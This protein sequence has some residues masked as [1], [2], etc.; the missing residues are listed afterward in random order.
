MDSVTQA[1]LNE[2]RESQALTHADTDSLFE[3][4]CNY[5]ILSDIY[6]D[7]FDVESVNTGEGEFGID[8][9][10]VLVNDHLIEDVDQLTDVVEDSRSVSV[11]FVFTQAKTTSK[12]NSGEVSKFLIAVR[13]FFNDTL[14]L[15]QSTKIQE[16]H[17]IKQELLK[18]AAKFTSGLPKLDMYYASLGTWA[19]DENINAIARS[20]KEEL[21]G[22][23]IFSEVAVNFVDARQLQALYYQTKNAFKATLP[24][25]NNVS[26]PEMEGIREAYLGTVPASTYLSMIDDGH[27]GVRD[28]LF[29]DNIRDYRGDTPVNESMRETIAGERRKEFPLRNNGV[30]IVC[31]N[32]QR[33]GNQF[34]IEDFQIVNGCQTSHVLART[35]SSI[36]EQD[37]D[38]PI[39]LIATD[40][41]EAI[42]HIIIGSNSQNTVD[43]QSFWALDPIHKNLEVLFQQQKGDRHL[44]YERRPGQYGGVTG[45]EKVRIVTKENLLKYYASMFLEEPNR[46]GRYY[47]D[48]LPMIGGAIFNQKH[49]LYPY[50]TAAYAAFRLEWL[51]RNG[52]IDRRYKNFRYQMLMAARLFIEREYG[53]SPKDTMKHSYCENINQTMEDTSD[54]ARIFGRASE[55][56]DEVVEEHEG[57]YS[58][59]IAKMRDTRDRMRERVAQ[60]E[61][62]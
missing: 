44:Y 51:F 55:I 48:L 31:R 58:L 10:C 29:F 19:D 41:E 42:R 24:F 4:F 61:I 11:R 27:G 33:V 7:E 47:K 18:S 30:T 57:E 21:D 26:M 14:T 23:N 35:R 43:Q 52:R 53:L 15:K 45:I 56:V 50:Y 37:F 34:H 12:F 5:I 1:L 46:V 32:L 59:R 62:E 22:L 13:D 17:N 25:A 39:K 60:A 2:F 36:E 20:H 49:E 16:A 8:G 3:H 54:A 40:D 38:V 28:K 9:I 6:S